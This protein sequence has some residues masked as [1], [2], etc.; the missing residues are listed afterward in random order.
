MN[1][2]TAMIVASIFCAAALG[3][4]FMFRSMA[5]RI[6]DAE[7]RTAVIESQLAELRAQ[8]SARILAALPPQSPETPAVTVRIAP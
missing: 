2:R 6:T 5:T 7:K 1:K 8:S 3:D 4:I